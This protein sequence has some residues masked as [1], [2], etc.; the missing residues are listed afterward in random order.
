MS[1]KG[2]SPAIRLGVPAAVFLFTAMVLGGSA[3][4]R[5]L[6]HDEHQ[7]VAAGAVTARTGRLPYL[8]YPYFHTPYLVFVHAAAFGLTDRLLA[9]ARLSSAACTLALLVLLY[10]LARR[11]APHRPGVAVA[12]VALLLANPLFLHTTGR[13]WN[14]EPAALLSVAAFLL[15][16]RAVVGAAGGAASIKAGAAGLATGLGAGVRL[17]VL[18]LAIPLGLMPLLFPR[19]GLARRRFSTIGA[20]GGGL[21]LGLLPL[22]WFAFRAPASFLY[23]NLGY[24]RVNTLYRQSIGHEI[25]MD[26]AG[27]LHYFLRAIVG[28]PGTFILLALVAGLALVRWRRA[29][30]EA[31]APAGESPGLTVRL[32]AL[33]AVL[34]TLP[35]V[36]G[37]ALAATPSWPHYFYAIVPLLVVAVV[38][39]LPPDSGERVH[40]AVAIAA[41]VCVAFAGS[42]LARAGSLLSPSGRFTRK[43]HAI[44]RRIA[45]RAGDGPVLTLAPVYPLEGGLPVYPALVTS[46]FAWRTAHLLDA[47][48][49]AQLGIVGPA[50]LDSTLD[51]RPPGAILVGHEPSLEG[52]FVRWGRRM[53]YTETRLPEGGVLLL[54]PAGQDR[55]ARRGHG[56][57]R[58]SARTATTTSPSRCC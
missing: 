8:D 33:G 46:P 3:L 57:P 44:G 31:P 39:G 11:R 21:A 16:W 40:R 1:E 25:A 38:E 12:A 27:K 29:P 2:P 34:W 9:A 19:P 17:S 15:Q 41:L 24:H 28:K 18:P 6:D 54:P 55:V 4:E 30:S 5:P 32:G 20:F 49:R 23:G 48:E 37:A 13:A 26:A 35:F 52:D 36:F 7:F 53:G 51:R 10:V 42:D 58:S 47:A 14:H 56:E 45:S 50:E 22:A 43:A